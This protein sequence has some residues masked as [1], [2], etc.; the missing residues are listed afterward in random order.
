MMSWS[1][2]GH[3]STSTRRRIL[4]RDNHTC[5]RC[6]AT[7]VPMEINHKDNTRG[8]GYNHD[9]NLETLCVPCHAVQTRRETAQGQ[10]RRAARRRLPQGRHPG[11]I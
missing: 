8:D 4:A 2:S 3:V 7:G 9:G 5:Q 11:L 6:G 10:A 1:N